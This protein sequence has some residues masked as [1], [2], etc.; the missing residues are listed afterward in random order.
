[1]RN[2]KLLSSVGL[3]FVI[4]CPMYI[5]DVSSDPPPWFSSIASPEA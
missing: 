4:I 1:M 3:V 5:T 2:D